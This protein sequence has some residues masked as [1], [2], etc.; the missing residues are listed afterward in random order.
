MS[1][2]VYIL[3]CHNQENAPKVVAT[4]K[5]ANLRAKILLKVTCT[6]AEQHKAAN[7]DTADCISMLTIQIQ[8]KILVLYIGK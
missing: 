5:K 1:S 7:Y 2:I 8:C 4:Y 3:Q 6:K